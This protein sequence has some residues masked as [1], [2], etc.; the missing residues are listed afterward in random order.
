MKIR[1]LVLLSIT[2]LALTACSSDV[3]GVQQ[4]VD[5]V[6]F[7][8]NKT[9]VN[10]EKSLNKA[11]EIS[12]LIK[13]SLVNNERLEDTSFKDMDINLHLDSIRTFYDNYVATLSDFYVGAGNAEE[14]YDEGLVTNTGDSNIVD[15]LDFKYYYDDANNTL[16]HVVYVITPDGNRFMLTLK[17]LNGELTGIEEMVSY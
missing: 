8:T 5:R 9:T 1:H 7:E 13:V 2:T 10:Y 11:K 12:E 14:D 6:N 15:W 17:W 4:T 16:D 3:A